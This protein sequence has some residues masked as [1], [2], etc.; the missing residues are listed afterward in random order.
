MNSR[1]EEIRPGHCQTHEWIFHDHANHRSVGKSFH[2]QLKEG[3]SM[4]WISGKAGSGKSTLTRFIREH[5]Q[6]E[7]ALETWA[8]SHPCVRAAFFLW[9][10]A[11][12][13][14]QKMLKGLLRTLLHQMMKEHPFSGVSAH[15]SGPKAHTRLDRGTAAFRYY[16]RYLGI[17][18]SPA[19]FFI[20]D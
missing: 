19:L 7:T 2:N 1:L 5:R 17:S 4:Y 12:S 18:T 20:I 6:I 3:N 16:S 15:C 13:S 10:P 8:G 14:L 9:N 11:V